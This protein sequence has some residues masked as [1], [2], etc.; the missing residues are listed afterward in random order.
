PKAEQGGSGSPKSLTL[1]RRTPG[2]L[3]L[4]PA[5]TPAPPMPL[6]MADRIMPA[7]AVPWLSQ[8]PAGAP[9]HRFGKSS[10]SRQS[11]PMSVPAGTISGWS[12]GLAASQPAGAGE[13]KNHSRWTPVSITITITL[14]DPNRESGDSQTSGALISRSVCVS[15]G[16]CPETWLSPHWGPSY[17]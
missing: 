16:H 4:G 1:A 10:G 5:A 13:G 6:F 7:T 17:G 3:P 11:T 9:S 15:P 12:L 8:N 2:V 14:G